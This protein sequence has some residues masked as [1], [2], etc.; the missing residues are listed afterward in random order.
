MQCPLCLSINIMI[1]TVWGFKD[2]LT[3]TLLCTC[4]APRPYAVF[5]TVLFMMINSFSR[6]SQPELTVPSVGRLR[7]QGR[8]FIEVK[9]SCL[10]TRCS[11]GDEMLSSGTETL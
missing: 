1:S 9:S 10:L 7:C 5:D 6:R 4:D 2:P 8:P 11:P 3:Q